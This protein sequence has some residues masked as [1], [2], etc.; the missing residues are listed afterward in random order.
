MAVNG[1]AAAKS[2]SSQ[3]RVELSMAGLIEHTVKC[4]WIP[5][6]QINWLGFDLDLSGGVISVPKNRIDT[7]HKQLEEAAKWEANIWHSPS[8]IRV[9]YSDASNT[10]YGGYMVEHSCHIAQGLWLPQ[11]A[12]LS[13]TWRE[14][15]AVFKV[16]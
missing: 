12:K 8:A 6:T 2:A 15:W 5:T 14:L 4:I 3:A 11:E 16:L 1:E 10:G 13:S 7:L 9:V